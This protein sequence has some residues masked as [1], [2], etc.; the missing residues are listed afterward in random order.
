MAPASP[1]PS[2]VIARIKAW[3]RRLKAE[4]TALW[5]A[6][7]D[8]RTPRAARIVALVVV[9]YAVSPIDLIPD[10]IPVLGFLDDAILLPLGV[11]LAIRL[12][13]PAVMTAAR[14]TAMQGHDRAAWPVAGRVAA[15]VIVA[16]WLIGA[17][18]AA[19]WLLG[20][21]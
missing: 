2:G 12:I 15:V 1:Q 11:M 8:P 13:P 7:R 6:L 21:G 17:G 16:L 14:A 4:I 18:M 3:A 10:F 9:A 19:R 20:G 5:H